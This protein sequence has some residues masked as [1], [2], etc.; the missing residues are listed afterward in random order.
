ET[1]GIKNMVLERGS[2]GEFCGLHF[3]DV[4]FS[5]S[6]AGFAGNTG[7]QTFFVKATVNSGE[8]CVAGEAAGDFRGF[9]RGIHGF[10]EIFT[11]KDGAGRC[12]VKSSERGEVCDARFVEA[13]VLLFKKVG[14]ADA[15]RSESPG[16][17]RFQRMRA[18]SDGV[19]VLLTLRFD[20][21]VDVS[22]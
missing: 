18:V 9:D 12:E 15:V 17:D 20:L 21:V 2:A 19:D 7:N 13:A 10:L 3:L 14:L 6:V 4:L 16:E 22:V 5:R 8:R 1:R 11:R